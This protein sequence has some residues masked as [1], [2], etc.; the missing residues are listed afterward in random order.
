MSFYEIY[1]KYEDYNIEEYI[2]GLDEKSVLS[3]FNKESISECEFLALLSSKSDKYIE[4]MAQKANKLT[5]NHFGRVMFIYT[6]MYLSNYCV[7]QCIYCGFNVKNIIS[8]K[9]LEIDEIEREAKYI[10]KKGFRHILI[11]TGESR[12]YSPV[13]YIKEAVKVLRNYFDSISIEIYPLNQ[14]EYKGLIEAGVDGLTIYQEVYNESV[15]EQ[16]HLS[17]PKKN[18]LF[19]LEAPERACEAKIRGVNIGALLGL[20]NWIKEAFYTGLHARYLQDKYLDTEIAISLPRIRPHVGEFQPK[21]FVSDKDL[22]KIMTAF[23]IFMPRAGISLSTRENASLRDNLI[24]LG[25][26]RMS[27]DSTTK[28]GGHSVDSESDSQFDISDNRNVEEMKD[29]VYKKG[30]QPIFKD[31]QSI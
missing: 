19:R 21:S 26:T 17:G 16:L 4:L 10:S 12:K 27:A 13:E 9:K 29:L 28:V 15:Y 14:S 2:N 1:K 24:G 25:V 8:R 22:V 3:I 31:W 7:N 5:I 20:D 11:L 6:P 18:Y 23:R 30:Y